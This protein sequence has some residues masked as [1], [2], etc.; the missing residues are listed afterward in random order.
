M[1]QC[2]KMAKGK[3]MVANGKK[4]FWILFV[5]FAIT[6][7]G[8]WIVPNSF[9]F[10]FYMLL[11]LSIL[12]TAFVM[13]FGG[14]SFV[15]GLAASLMVGVS[16]MAAEYLT[17]SLS[18]MIRNHYSDWQLYRIPNMPQLYLILIGGVLF[19][20]GWFLGFVFRSIRRS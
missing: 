19:L 20:L 15:K 7:V 10:I 1:L 4:T 11:P 6:I 16:C 8:F 13:G 17:L 3:I 14:C 9:Y 2:K 5:S 18:N 12:V